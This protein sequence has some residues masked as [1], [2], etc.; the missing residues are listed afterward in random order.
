MVK[1]TKSFDIDFYEKIKNSSTVDM[2]WETM[3]LIVDGVK[4]SIGMV[5]NDMNEVKIDINDKI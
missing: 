2:D 3:S 5:D 1:K 4:H